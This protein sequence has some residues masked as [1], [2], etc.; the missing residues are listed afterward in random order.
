MKS[1][2]H[3]LDAVRELVRSDGGFWEILLGLRCMERILAFNL[4]CGW[5]FV[6]QRHLRLLVGSFGAVSD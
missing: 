4:V 5:S 2:S 6:R 1:Q 3:Q